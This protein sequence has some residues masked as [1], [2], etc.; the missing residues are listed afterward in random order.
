MTVF[1]TNMEHSKV[2]EEAKEKAKV[3]LLGLDLVEII[4]KVKVNDDLE[5]EKEEKVARKDIDLSED[6]AKA[7]IKTHG[8][9]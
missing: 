4:E 7:S 6:Q 1:G 9:M 8:T 3:D 5:E 2:I